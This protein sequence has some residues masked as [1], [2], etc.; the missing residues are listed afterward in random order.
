MNTDATRGLK[1]SIVTPSYNQ[2]HFIEETIR[3]VVNQDY[4]N[5]EY[6][7]IDGGS[8]DST[9]AHLNNYSA[10]IDY[11]SSEP[12]DGQADAIGKGFELASGDIMG[13]LNSDDVL[14]PGALSRVADYFESRPSISAVSG[15][16][17]FIDENGHPLK[18]FGTF[19]LGVPASYDRFRYLLAQDGVFQPSTFWRSRDYHAVGGIDRKLEFIMDL[20]LF[21]RLAKRG[22][23]DN[24]EPRSLVFV[25]TARTNRRS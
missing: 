2:G 14:L 19:S 5:V 10:Q 21:T 24:F 3:S 4:P 15:G 8:T 20:D 17:Y 23:S 1:I 11:F 18:G 12:D 25:T 13:W 16:G 22:N 7:V 9:T 6:I